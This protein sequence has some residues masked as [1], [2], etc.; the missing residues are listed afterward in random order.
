MLQVAEDVSDGALLLKDLPEGHHRTYVL[1]KLKKLAFLLIGGQDESC[2]ESPIYI[3]LEVLAF[4]LFDLLLRLQ[5][6]H[7]VFLKLDP[8]L[9]S[10]PIIVDIIDE[11]SAVA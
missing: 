10:F 6:L 11:V 1:A 2:V 3:H 9:V 8:C 5:F 7:V 4:N